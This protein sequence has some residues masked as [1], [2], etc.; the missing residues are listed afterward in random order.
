MIQE[1]Q[2]V[3]DQMYG[4]A[5]ELFPLNR[6][7]TGEGL[8]KTLQFI[9]NL[10]PDLSIHEVKSGTKANDWE[11]PEEWN[12]NEAYLVDLENGQKIDFKDN[13]LHLMGY[14]VPVNKIIT[15]EEL[16]GHLHSL[17]NQPD[18]IPYVT[19]YYSRDWA[20]CVSENQKR[21]LSSGDFK[22]VIDSTLEA[23]VMN[24]A[25]LFIPGSNKEEILLSTYV[26]HPSMASNELSGPVIALALSKWLKNKK[27]RNFSYRILFIPET[28]GSIY[29]I[30]KNLKEMKENIKAGW[31]LTCL[32][33]ENRYSYVPS[34]KGGTLADRVSQK[35]LQDLEVKFEKYSFLERG[36]DER[37]YCSP[38]VDLPVASL[39]RSKYGTYEEYH[40]SLDDLKYITSKGLAESLEMLKTSIDILEVN[41]FWKIKTLG[42]PQ[43]G[44]RGLYPTVST[45]ESRTLVRD[46]MN[47]IAYCDG[48][49]D[50]IEISDICNLK[51]KRVSKII[52]VLLEHDLVEEVKCKNEN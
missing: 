21:N 43:L 18:A 1:P 39:M 52:E 26:C 49:T 4:W 27:H 29:Y 17:P 33:D 34:R 6:S 8:R 44:K 14:S 11:I 50:M 30:S 32:G 28:I 15:R 31:V 46:L 40:T 13:N 38:G 41:K 20:F 23:G 35:T 36:S 16:E 37:Q 3:G 22:V 19:S 47:V 45:K 9:K 5:E 7:L 42:E 25:E 2:F 24:F 51:F 10:C 48:E 12:V